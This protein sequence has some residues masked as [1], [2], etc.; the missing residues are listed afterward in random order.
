MLLIYSLFAIIL[1][2]ETS[3]QLFGRFGFEF[4]GFSAPEA[5]EDNPF[6]NIQERISE[7]MK[8]SAKPRKGV[9]TKIKTEQKG[10][11][12]IC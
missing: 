10:M 5:F 1:L 7:L 3:G 6:T 11:F 4:P 9:K 2:N 12:T 8:G